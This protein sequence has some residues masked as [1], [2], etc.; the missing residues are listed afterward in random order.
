MP[1]RRP[2]V[3][4]VA[5]RRWVRN[6]IDRFILAR[7]EQAGL[8]PSPEAD[9]ATLLRRRQPRPDRPAAVAR[10]G[11][12]LPGRS[13]ARP[14]SSAPSI[15]CWPRPISAS[16]GR[17]PGSTRPATPIPTATT[18]TPRA[19]SGS[20][21]T[22]SS[23]PSTP[24]CRSTGSR[25]TRSPATSSRGATLGAAD[26]HR[27][28]PEHADQPGRRDRRRAVPG[29]VDRRS[30]QHDRDGL[31]RPDDRLRPVPRPQVRPDQPA[32]VLPALRLLQQRGRARA[33]DRH[34][35]RSWPDASEIRAQID[36]FHRELAARYPDL[37]ERERRWEETLTLDVHAE[38]RRPT[39][40]L[41][42]DV[43]RE[44]RSHRPAPRAGRADDRARPGVPGRA[45]RLSRSFASR[46][47]EVRHD[48]GRRAS[49]R[50]RR[51]RRSCTWAATSRGRASGS[52]RASR[53]S[54]LALEDASPGTPARSDGPGPLAGRSPQSADGPGGG[55]PDLAGVFRPRP[56]RDRQRFRH[57]GLAAQPSRAARL[58]GLRADGRGW[59]LKAIHRLIV[60]LG[61][62][63][64]GVAGPSRG[65]GDRSRQPAA[66]AA[67]AAAARRRADPR[68]GPG[69]QRAARRDDRRPE[70]LPAPA[71]GRH[72]PGPDETPVAG[73]HRARTA[74]AAGSTPSSG[75]RRRYPFLT[76]FDAPGGVQTCTRRLRSNTPLQALTL[77]NDP[78]FVE[79]ARGLA[80]ADPARMPAAGERSRAAR[81]CLP[82]LP[83]PSRRRI[84]SCATLEDV[85]DQER[86][87]ASAPDATAADGASGVDR[88]SL[89]CC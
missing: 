82:A 55:Q 61:D 70:R 84:G 14:L 53:P 75:G 24:T 89:A 38:R 11:R 51:D 6:P 43:P 12:R 28:P 32:R 72:E 83:G 13:V 9:P 85:P 68:R 56:G 8:S 10:G 81:P 54:C 49:D 48:D 63:P 77:L 35:R 1:P 42:F 3:P 18:S 52:S 17:A 73:R 80:G 22:G 60:E 65:P 71:R 47:A 39:S 25:S 2:A 21:A 31:P 26:R 34:A 62:V 86:E 4:E 16:G 45:A 69:E 36:A 67:V 20:T 87:R 5:D 50:V 27:V 79:I 40:E 29:R 19:R 76:T 44:K 41:A 59:S 23:P 58:A 46:R 88:P 33:G 64:P 30:G 57:P 15:A 7:L 37:D 74:T 66:L 78:A